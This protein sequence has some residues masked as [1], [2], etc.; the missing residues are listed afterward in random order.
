MSY[1]FLTD[2]DRLTGSFTS[3]YDVTSTGDKFTIAMWMKRSAAQWLTPPDT[4]FI[5][6][7]DSTADT[8]S[9]LQL[10]GTTTSNEVRAATIDTTGNIA[11]DS[12]AH[13]VNT[14]DD[15]WVLVVGV[16]DGDADRECFFNGTGSG[17][18]NTNQEDI[19]AVGAA[20]AIGNNV[21]TAFSEARCLI[22]EVGMWDVALSDAEVASLWTSA[23]TG[24]AMDSVQGA[25]CVGYWPLLADSATHANLGVD[26]G[27]L[28][29]VQSDAT[30]VDDHPTITTGGVTITDVD[31]DEIWD[32]GDSGLVITGTG[33]V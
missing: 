29:T 12:L 14:Q 26:T 9:S 2:L 11:S 4:R 15:T 10:W 33:F 22:A 28:M 21:S 30:W 32:D 18:P 31:T 5:M 27:G 16:F 1:S 19:N 6:I 24:P 8:N 20:I 3:T 13:T 25:N 17:S 23:E 7:S